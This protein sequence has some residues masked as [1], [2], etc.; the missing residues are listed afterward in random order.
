MSGAD[1]NGAFIAA[2]RTAL[3][4]SAA[5]YPLK[6]RVEELTRNN[7]VETLF[8]GRDKL[9]LQK[10][11][12]K[13][14][15]KLG[16]GDARFCGTLQSLQLYCTLTGQLPNDVLLGAEKYAG[17]ARVE[18]LRF[19]TIRELA[20]ELRRSGAAPQ[21]GCALPVL[22]APEQMTA[23]FLFI[24]TQKKAGESSVCM[25]FAISEPDGYV[26]TDGGDCLGGISTAA[27]SSYYT[28]DLSRPEGSE[29]LRE[30]YVKIRGEFEAVCGAAESQLSDA[31]NEFYDLMGQWARREREDLLFSWFPPRSGPA[32]ETN[33]PKKLS[34][35][36]D[37]MG[38]RTGAREDR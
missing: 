27:D 29:R 15:G 34:L 24:Y 17:P 38:L 2:L 26:D 16:G 11:L 7:D 19:E 33:E 3:G 22:Y 10:E 35:V 12:S 23:V 4:S 31:V 32:A 14:R 28:A 20:D 9:W 5:D 6:S 13:W 25:R 18:F 21:H 36:L 30:A 37:G 1:Y 8:P